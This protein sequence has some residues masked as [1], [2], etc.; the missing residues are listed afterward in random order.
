MKM[1]QGEVLSAMT[2]Q[3]SYKQINIQLYV[4]CLTTNQKESVSTTHFILKN[5]KI[6]DAPPT[7]EANLLESSRVDIQYSTMFISSQLHPY[8]EAVV[9]TGSASAK[10][11]ASYPEPQGACLATVRNTDLYICTNLYSVAQPVSTTPKSL[12][13]TMKSNVRDGNYQHPYTHTQTDFLMFEN[14]KYVSSGLFF[15]KRNFYEFYFCLF[16]IDCAQ[17]LQEQGQSS[18]VQ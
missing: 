11:R 14:G 13:L 3:C 8:A 7:R 5:K 10:T 17:L 16:L 2:H 18:L 6:T 1:S 9:I 12:L 15:I 4:L